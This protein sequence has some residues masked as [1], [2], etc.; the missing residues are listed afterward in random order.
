MAWTRSAAGGCLVICVRWQ[1][2]TSR[3][4]CFRLAVFALDVWHQGWLRSLGLG[5]ANWE[6]TPRFFS[7][8]RHLG[9]DTSAE[10]AV[11]YVRPFTNREFPAAM[12]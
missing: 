8:D 3:R 5:W 4:P 6:L 12:L 10:R 7:S 1:R 11:N 9:F 2:S